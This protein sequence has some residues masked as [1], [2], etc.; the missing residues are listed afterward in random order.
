MESSSGETRNRSSK[1]DGMTRR[2]LL[3][4]VA[5]SGAASLLVSVPELRASSAPV[6]A[7]AG[8][9]PVAS[10]ILW[11]FGTRADADGYAAH[12]VRPDG[13]VAATLDDLPHAVGRSGDGKRIVTASAGGGRPTEV[14]VYDATSGGTLSRSA[15]RFTWPAE[16]D[17]ALAVDPQSGQV[18]VAGL[19]LEGTPA[20]GYAEKQAPNGGMRRV[21]LTSWSAK[22]GLEIFTRS[23]VPTLSDGPHSTELG[24]VMQVAHSSGRTL[25]LQHHASHTRVRSTGDAG[26]GRAL[27]QD[28]SGHAQLVHVDRQGRAYLMRHDGNLEILT[29]PDQAATAEIDL[30]SIESGTAYPY[31]VSVVDASANTVA[32]VDASRRFLALVDSS[33][34]EVVRRKTLQTSQ[35]FHSPADTVGQAAAVDLTRRRIFVLDRSGTAGGA[36]VLDADNL[37]VVDRLHSDTMF[38]LVWVAQGSGAVFMQS[39][40]GPIA[41]HDA[42]GHVVGYVDSELHTAT[43]L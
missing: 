20:G 12:A 31:P 3:R 11:L 23:G 27:D 41:V 10:D 25:V 7:D 21:P 43:A 24:F 39:N 4:G 26:P 2:T 5:A 1:L 32:V 9:E 18:A 30:Y 28:L 42:T 35:A 13:S 8:A 16:P 19:A 33:T 22:E 34:G 37:D 38:R 40:D 14:T 15:G 36:W 17:L 6:A 29:Q